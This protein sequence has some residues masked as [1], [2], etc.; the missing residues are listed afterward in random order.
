[1]QIMEKSAQNLVAQSIQKNNRN[2]AS[3][4]HSRRGLA[5]DSLPAFTAVQDSKKETY[6]CPTCGKNRRREAVICGVKYVFHVMCE[7]EAKKEKAE[8]KARESRDRMRKIE[9]LKSLSLL[10]EKY[11]T[12]TF[13]RTQTGINPS[14]D[15]AFNRCKKYCEF[16]EKTVKNGYGIYLFGDKGVGKTHLT[17]CMANF[18]ISKYVPVLFTNLFEISKAVKSTFSRESSQ[19]E[20]ALIEKFSSIDILFFDDLGLIEKFSSIDILFFDDLGTELFT[21]SSGETWLQGLLF[22]L[23][24]KRYNNRKATIFSSNYSLNALVNERGIMEKTVDRIS[25]MTS[26]AVMKITGRSLRSRFKDQ[27]LF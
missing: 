7:C 5:K 15:A 8:Q 25:E 2:A 22:D 19:T 26:G 10:G 20:Q 17:A 24:N 6:I 23:I 27:N 13:E 14:F 1:M 9:K 18:L 21:R 4:S 12:V 11:K 3:N 16:Y